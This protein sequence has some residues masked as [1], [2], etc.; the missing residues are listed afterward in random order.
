MIPVKW[1][2]PR[3]RSV[4]YCSL[5]SVSKYAGTSYSFIIYF[6]DFSI[7]DQES[8]KV[9][10]RLNTSFPFAESVSIQK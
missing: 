4:I 10:V 6:P 7:L 8:F 3:Q 2:I 5:I 1:F 9:A